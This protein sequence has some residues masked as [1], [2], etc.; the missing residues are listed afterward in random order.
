MCSFELF[1]F[2]H[3]TRLEN[4]DD[5]EMMFLILLF[6]IC[7]IRLSFILKSLKESVICLHVKVHEVCQ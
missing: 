6:L 2:V 7:E 3:K 5:N 4:I 1:M